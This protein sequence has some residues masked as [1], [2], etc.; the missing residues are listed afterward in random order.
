MGDRVRA[1]RASRYIISQLYAL[2]YY[3]L[4][5]VPE[6]MHNLLTYNSLRFP[7]FAFLCFPFA[8]ADLRTLAGTSPRKDHFNGK[9]FPLMKESWPV[10]ASPG[11]CRPVPAGSSDY[12]LSQRATQRNAQR[13]ACGNETSLHSA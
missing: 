6:N 13:G 7:L 12:Y 4:F 9:P 2:L 11:E 10:P 1:D 5:P 8:L 3:F